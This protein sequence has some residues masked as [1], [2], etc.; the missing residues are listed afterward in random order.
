LKAPIKGAA[1]YGKEQTMKKGHWILG[2]KYSPRKVKILRWVAR[3]WSLFVLGLALVI[4]FTP[5]P[6]TTRPI[7]LH[8][9]FMLSI[10]GVA[11]LGLILAWRWE[12]FGALLTIITM[13]IREILYIL[14]Y[15]EWTINFLLIWA[16]VI[17]PAVMYL[18]AWRM[19]HKHKA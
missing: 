6:Y 12:R 15:R 5:D 2:D 19:D 10:W 16:L 14:F 9:A 7:E 13:P 11:I 8:E 17:P 3:I 4:A 18:L 1:E